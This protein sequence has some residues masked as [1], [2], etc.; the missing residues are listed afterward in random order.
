MID[1]K[2]ITLG[3]HKGSEQAYIDKV[4]LAIRVLLNMRRQMK[5]RVT[6]RNRVLRNLGTREKARVSLVLE[7][8]ALPPELLE[9]EEDFVE[10]ESIKEVN[11]LE[12]VPVEP[13]K[14]PKA[15]EQLGHGPAKSAQESIE[16]FGIVELP[17]VFKRLSEEVEG[18]PKPFAMLFPQKPKSWSEQA[19]VAQAMAYVPPQVHQSGSKAKRKKTTDESKSS[20]KKEQPKAK[21]QAKKNTKKKQHKKKTQAVKAQKKPEPKKKA[22]PKAKARMVEANAALSLDDVP[23]AGNGSFTFESATYGKCKLERYKEK[24]Y[25]RH[26]VDDKW[27]NIIG[28]NATGHHAECCRRLAPYVAQGKS[29]DELYQIRAEILEALMDVE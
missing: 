29:S 17:S 13:E 2:S 5:Q 10:A 19:I 24:S 22:A 1:S 14:V 12:W 4:D 18:A 3:S 25:L 7:K 21:K 20:E 11:C 23:L 27:R 26:L 9:Q 8:L 15:K 28:S 6:V 16:V